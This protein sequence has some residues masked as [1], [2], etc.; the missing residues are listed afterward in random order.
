MHLLFVLCNP[1]ELSASCLI[2]KESEPETD[3]SQAILRAF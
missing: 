2:K 1:D 3:K